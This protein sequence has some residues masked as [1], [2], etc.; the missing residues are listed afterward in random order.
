VQG[1]DTLEKEIKGLIIEALMLEDTT[2]EDIE[3]AEPL[4]NAGLGLDS[5]DALEL[6]IVLESRYGIKLDEDSEE[7][8][9]IF[10]SVRSLATFVSENRSK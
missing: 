7:N 10:A 4:F 8:Q 2:P 6:A 1:L 3:T 5:I 9:E